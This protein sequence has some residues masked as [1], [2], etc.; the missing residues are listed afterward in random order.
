MSTESNSKLQ[1]GDKAPD[2]TLPTQKTGEAFHLH[3]MLGKSSI[4]VYFYPKD[5]TPGCTAE[6]C[7]FRDS[8]EVFKEAGAEVIGISTD[9]A[10]S[11]QQFASKYSL[12]FILLSD[13]GGTVQN[14]YSVPA[15]THQGMTFASRVTYVIDKQGVVKNIFADLPSAT[16][17]VSDALKTIQALG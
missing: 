10:Q 6:A 15:I 5:D 3:D 2:F 16:Q 8:Y 1:V 14:L 17:H 11:H 4:V 7:S 12:P 9:T 13:E